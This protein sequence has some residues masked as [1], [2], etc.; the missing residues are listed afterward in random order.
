MRKKT[1]YKQLADYFIRNQDAI[2]CIID[3]NQ[4]R[5]KADNYLHYWRWM[6]N[7]LVK[8]ILPK[9]PI[10]F[11]EISTGNY[12]IALKN[13]TF[14]KEEYIY[15]PCEFFKTELLK[16]NG[17]IDSEFG[18]SIDS[19]LLDKLALSIFLF[20]GDYKSEDDIGRSLF[21]Y[22]EDNSLKLTDI[23]EYL[24]KR[25]HNVYPKS[26]VTKEIEKILQKRFMIKNPQNEIAKGSKLKRL[27]KYAE[28]KNIKAD[29]LIEFLK[30]KGYHVRTHMSLITEEMTNDLEEFLAKNSETPKIESKL[31]TNS[32]VENKKLTTNLVPD[33]K[34]SLAEKEELYLLID[35]EKN[36]L[37]KE[38]AEFRKEVEN[39]LNK[40]YHEKENIESA[41]VGIKKEHDQIKTII[42]QFESILEKSSFVLQ[43]NPINE[44]QQPEKSSRQV[45]FI[46]TF[47]PEKQI[48]SSIPETVKKEFEKVTKNN[49]PVLSINELQK[50]LKANK[51]IYST[52]LISALD[53]AIKSNRL[54][55]MYGKP[56]FGKSQLITNYVK[57]FNKNITHKL[58]DYTYAF[59]PV[60]PDW[61]DPT[62]ILG[63]INYLTGEHEITDFVK[64]AYM[65]SKYPYI[66]FFVCFDEFNLSRPENYFAPFLSITELEDSHPKRELEI[67]QGNYCE[68][69]NPFKLKIGNNLKFLCT[70]NE[71]QS[72]FELSPK[73]K[74]RADLIN[75]DPEKD[76]YINTIKQLVKD[77]S[78]LKIVAGFISVWYEHRND[79]PIS[80]RLLSS[81]QLNQVPNI[82]IVFSTRLI[83]SLSLHSLNGDFGELLDDL[84]KYSNNKNLLMTSKKLVT[85]KNGLF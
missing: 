35:T 45:S 52:H 15:V 50:E 76:E 47:D 51:L 58:I 26:E 61:T 82:D 6:K 16:S 66:T 57:N 84:I 60:K 23:I 14:G 12:A 9:L 3:I 18:F 67:F 39:D 46:K 43:L 79:P 21:R 34:D 53:L 11:S 4:S 70:I 77:N 1:P 2:K 10:N 80:Y 83:N 81:L 64:I 73:V 71:D 48:Q 33:R 49:N 17:K 13:V 30:Q 27:Y 42:N 54:A 75:C 59:I 78:F 20:E 22:A 28:E 24:K 69:G 44:N 68:S 32:P 72:T 25:G 55:I 85:I 62:N 8:K 7:N 74:D 41:L 56:G 29:D 5:N 40:I 63:S 36:N 65:A 19:S 38:L 31:K 37:I